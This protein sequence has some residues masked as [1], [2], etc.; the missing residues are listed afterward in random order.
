MTVRVD[1]TYGV[2]TPMFCS[3]SDPGRP[4]LRL[5]SFKGV[6]R[7][8]WR[9][10]AWAEYGADYSV[11]RTK[12]S[13]LFGSAESGQSQ[14]DLRMMQNPNPSIV[15]VGKQLCLPGSGNREIGAGARYLGYGVMEA[16]D[17][18]KRNKRA[19]QLTRACFQCPFEFT[20]RMRVRKADQEDLRMLRKALIALGTL[21]GMGAKSRKGYGSLVLRSVRVD[22]ISQWRPPQS[23]DDLKSAIMD[24]RPSYTGSGLPG[25][26][27]FSD[28]SR[29]VL[30]TAENQQPVEMLDLVGQELVRFRSWG[31]DGK[32]LGSEPSERNFKRDHD[33]MKGTQ[34]DRHPERVA[35]GLPHNYG[36]Y[37]DQQ[38]GPFARDLD[39]RA[40]PLF[41]HIHLC[42]SDPV[43]VAT[44]LPARFLPEGKRYIS[45][46]RQ[47]VKQM[48]EDQ[49]Y[50]PIHEFLDRLRDQRTR[51][52]PSFSR[53]V[54][55]KP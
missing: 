37:P 50:R 49:L 6:L 44:M 42:G 45:V 14:V 39:R 35:F 53:S 46:G 19:G 48:P 20:V 10:L 30:L 27:A 13:G 32:I 7:F 4:E 15:P 26:T 54:E 23:L 17:S 16:F 11:I 31:K 33:L 29:H 22:G 18:R 5:S 21:G 38:V 3:G 41:L 24:L 52:S 28:K 40:S 25:F 1:A 51:T 12:E 9:A 8:W 2:V 36:K 34:R 55:V 43:A 47:K